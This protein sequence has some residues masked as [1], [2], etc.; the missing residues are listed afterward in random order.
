MPRGPEVPEAI[1]NQIVGMRRVNATFPQIASILNIPQNTVQKIYYRW[2]ETS[3]CSNAPRSGAP[4]KLTQ[5]DLTHIERHVRHDREQRR[6]PLGEII[7]DLNL[8]V[9]TYT[10]KR[11]LVY[12]LGLGHRIER[13]TPWL[14]KAQKAARLAF[15][16]EHISWGLDEWRRVIFSD[17]MGMQT[18]ANQKA[19]YVWRYPEEE[20]LE[21]CCGA[22]VI[23]GFQKI[24]VWGAMRYG[25]LSELVV[26]P[27]K[28][29]Q[30][31]LN[32]VEY[33]AII[34]D[35]ELLDFWM[36]SMEEEGYV[37]VMEDGAPYHKGAASLRRKEYEKMGWIGWGP[38]TWPSNSPDL[39]PI[40]NL[41]HVLR[42]NIRKRKRQPRTAEELALAL[43]EEWKKL[44]MK[45]VQ[46]L[47]DSM[48][49]RMQAVIDA[50]G[51]CTHY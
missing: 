39:N 51:G 14:S 9:S 8:P 25:A 18:G 32:A 40:E 28:E 21:D 45:V 11:S 13:K 19:V 5:R 4:K 16:K 31:K 23:P 20:Y 1:R 49:R 10:L 7:L 6:Q 12:D 50:K 30:G 46:A 26:M 29:G 15:A 48:P 27:E 24:K 3:D 37:L 47:I 22:T 42:S 33:T 43:Q 41:W 35:G 44:D 34:L 17:E 36:R 38:G 2:Q